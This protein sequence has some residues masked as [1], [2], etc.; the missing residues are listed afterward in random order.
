MALPT[1]DFK[2]YIKDANG[3]PQMVKVIPSSK[4]SV[5]IQLQAGSMKPIFKIPSTS[6]G[7]VVYG[8]KPK[9]VQ[10]PL[11]QINQFHKNTQDS[12]TSQYSTLKK[13]QTS[14]VSEVS[15][16]I[17]TVPT[18]VTHIPKQ[19]S[20]TDD[21]SYLTNTILGYTHKKR[22]DSE[23]DIIVDYS[24]KRRK[25]VEKVGKG[26]RH[27]SMKVCEKVR[28]KGFTS[29]NE[30]ADELVAEFTAGLKACPD[31]QQYDHK[32]IRRRVYDALNVLMAMNIISKEKKEIRWIGLPTNSAQECS[33]LEAEKQIKLERIQK[34]TQQLQDLI[35]KQISFKCLVERNKEA[36]TQGLMPSSKSTIQLPFIVV[37]TNEKTLINC[38]IS[39][40]K[41][42]YVF[43][44]NE[45]FQI[46]DDIDILKRMG[47]VLG[48][49]TGN[50]TA[51]NL[52][53]AKSMVPKSLENYVDQL[54]QGNQVDVEN[55]INIKC[56]NEDVGESSLNDDVDVDDFDESSLQY[57]GEG[58]DDQD[59]AS[60]L[61]FN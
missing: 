14:N 27:F 3:Q 44:F 24:S 50:C 20:Q 61:D 12:T 43:N 40:D 2:F 22:H 53:K 7:G 35:L 32:N 52:K 28:R 42:E 6:E 39:N 23:N 49:D 11:E 13:V 36:E 54:A 51:E 4:T 10:V 19:S 26:L 33:S 31:N 41:M 57:S 58:D 38:S 25:M 17:R 48:L 18:L 46:Q 15:K 16:V 59:E 29:Y 45:K 9:Y 21:K 47:L 1:Q 56:E 34:K 60:D 5:P 30:V 55:W 37:N 8:V